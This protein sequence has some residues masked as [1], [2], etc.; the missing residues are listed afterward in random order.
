MQCYADGVAPSDQLLWARA[1]GRTAADGRLETRVRRALAM[2][3]LYIYSYTHVVSVPI[4]PQ[5]LPYVR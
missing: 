2:T 4:C 3:S 1:G 5:F